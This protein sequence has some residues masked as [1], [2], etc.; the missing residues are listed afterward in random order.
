M[1][2]ILTIIFVAIIAFELFAVT[3]FGVYFALKDL[4]NGK[5][6]RLLIAAF[7]LAIPAVVI[8]NILGIA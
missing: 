3:P 1:T 4:D 7:V 5:P 8:A 6:A 2:T